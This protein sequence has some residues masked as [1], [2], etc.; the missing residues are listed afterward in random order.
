MA[1]DDYCQCQLFTDGDISIETHRTKSSTN[2]RPRFSGHNGERCD[3]SQR[4]LGVDVASIIFNRSW[5]NLPRIWWARTSSDAR[6]S[7][8]SCRQNKQELK[9]IQRVAIDIDSSI[10]DC[11][12]HH[13]EASSPVHIRSQKHVHRTCVQ[14]IQRFSEPNRW[15]SLEAGFPEAST[16]HVPRPPVTFREHAAILWPHAWRSESWGVRSVETLKIQLFVN[17][18]AWKRDACGKPT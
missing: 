8:A 15:I 18:L 2:S 1:N 17:P 12:N 10:G 16:P 4:F 6:V 9:G 13:T 14:Y 3:S 5:R 11:K 7:I